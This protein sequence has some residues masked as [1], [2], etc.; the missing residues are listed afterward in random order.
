MQLYKAVIEPMSNFSTTLKGDT[1]FGHICWTIFYRQKQLRLNLNS[2]LEKYKNGKPFV[3]VSDAFANGYLPKPKIPSFL[4]GEDN[5][6]KKENRKKVWLK[7]RDLQNG[8]YKNAKKDSEVGLKDKKETIIRNSINYKTFTTDSGNFAPYGV[9]E[10][11]LSKK[12][13]YFLIDEEQI[14]DVALKEII[15][16]IGEL[17]YGKDSTIGKGRFIVKD[18]KKVEMN[19]EATTFMALSPFVIDSET[20]Q[21]IYYEPFV[22]FGKFGGSRAH[23]NA[24][25][26]FVLLADSGA[27]IEF[28]NRKKREFLG[29]AI[30]NLSKKYSDSVMQGYSILL[31]IKDLS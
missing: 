11:T 30:T 21:R 24:F 12:D 20:I 5:K 13:I 29:K 15:D 14:S 10:L 17:G 7:L 6:D 27:V 31:P 28:K 9:E 8:N 2:L 25:K 18:F 3:I 19:F 26:N 1:F 23:V 4:L 16:F 22:R